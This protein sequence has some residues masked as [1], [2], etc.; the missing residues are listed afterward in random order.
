MQ[1]L[2][3]T[4]Q[5]QRGAAALIVVLVLLFAMALVA[6]FAN[7][8]LLFEQRSSANQYRSTQAFEAAEAGIEWALAQL[9]ANQ[10]IG[11]DCRPGTDPTATSFRSRY[12][13][14][15]AKTG[16]ATPTTWSNAGVST[17][18]QASCTRAGNGWSCSCPAQGLPNLPAPTAAT[19]AAAFT[20][21]FAPAGKPGIVRLIANG[22]TSLAG[23]CL[24]GAT[25]RADASAR[26][27]VALG[28]VAGL[29]TPPAATVTTRAGFDAGNAAIGLHNTD[30]STGIAVSAGGT[31]D[32]ALARLTPPAGAP[33]TGLLA[34]NDSALAAI[35]ADRLFASY[36]GVDKAAWQAQPAVTRIR[37]ALDCAT[38]L[39]EAIAAAADAA[40]IHVDGDL[41]LAGPLTLGSV[42]RAVVIVVNGTAQFDGAVGLS[43]LLYAASVR[44]NG[45]AGAAFVRGALISEG[46]YQ[47][48]GAPELFY[49]PLV[50]DTLKH[51]SGSF[52][53]INGSWRDF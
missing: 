1:I 13:S 43:G 25:G 35:P 32:A 18:L 53:R 27:E 30:P 7:R 20:V 21:Q 51:T 9:N 49:D 15:A 50:L 42:Q 36:F 16:V 14:I 48:N 52:A 12:L 44:W 28:L 38:Q 31:I 46:A 11:A 45:T 41:V 3:S 40:L 24:T 4:R 26:I 23:A 33:T 37:C 6:T 17:P 10:R 22:C 29:G 34:A 8:N 19:P 39:G 47:G 5:G 2:S